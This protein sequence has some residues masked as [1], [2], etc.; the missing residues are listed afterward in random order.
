MKFPA[1]YTQ[2][3]KK[4]KFLVTVVLLIISVVALLNAAIFVQSKRANKRVNDFIATLNHSDQIV[5]NST[6]NKGCES[7]EDTG[8]NFLSSHTVICQLNG[9]KFYKSGGNYQQTLLNIE[10][11]LKQE[12]REDVVSGSGCSTLSNC[13]VGKYGEYTGK[14]LPVTRSYGYNKPPYITLIAFHR[15]D[16]LTGADSSDYAHLQSLLIDDS[17]FI[18][19]YELSDT[20]FSYTRLFW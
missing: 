15:G 6:K 3:S 19:G 2:K 18:Y 14:Y 8:I 4:V 20:Y 13:L 17:E 10:T 5:M 1:L 7:Y 11:K 9:F 12:G 16:Q